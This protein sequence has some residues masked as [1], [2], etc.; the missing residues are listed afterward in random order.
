MA[1]IG[2]RHFLIRKTDPTAD[3]FITPTYSND[4]GMRIGNLIS[5]DITWNSSNTKLHGDDRLVLMDNSAT[6]GTLKIETTY[7]P[8]DALYTMLGYKKGAGQ[9]T[10]I[11]MSDE[12]SPKVG[13]GFIVEVINEAGTKSYWVYWY[14]LVQF[15]MNNQNART[16]EENTAYGVPTIE[17]E[18]FKTKNGFGFI[19]KYDT[20]VGAIANLDD[21][22]NYDSGY[23]DDAEET[24]DGSGLTE[25]PAEETD[26]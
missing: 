8:K 25:V 11:Y 5:A 6:G 2:L 18:I 14:Y 26:P 19:H 22:A 3:N 24:D 20:E 4:D 9:D 10:K 15:T 23:I 12:P 17:G 13:A 21:L 16:R 1:Q 7:I